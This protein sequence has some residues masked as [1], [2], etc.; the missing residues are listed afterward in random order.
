M[1]K[2]TTCSITL[3]SYEAIGTTLIQKLLDLGRIWV[4]NVH[5]KLRSLVSRS[6]MAPDL[7]NKSK[8]GFICTFQLNFNAAWIY[9]RQTL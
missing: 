1:D 2:Y 6:R 9:G 3:T 4:S 5:R 7:F 8:L